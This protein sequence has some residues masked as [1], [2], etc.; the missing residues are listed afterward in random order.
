MWQSYVIF[1]AILCGMFLQNT[2]AYLYVHNK[3]DSLDIVQE[4]SYQAFKSIKNLKNPQY[5]KTWMMRILM[6]TAVKFKKNNS[7]VFVEEVANEGAS[8]SINKEEHLDLLFALNELKEDYRLV[9][10]LHYYHDLTV[11]SISEVLQIPEGTVKTNL[12]RGREKLKNKLTGV[13]VIKNEQRKLK[14]SY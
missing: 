13:G 2:T 9:I 3:E 14:E 11:K 10:I 1:F 6:N 8:I 7:I 12:F 5:F 4:T